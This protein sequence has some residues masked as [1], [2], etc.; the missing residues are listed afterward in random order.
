MIAGPGTDAPL[1]V[2]ISYS[3]KDR[4][5]AE[6]LRTWLMER[7]LE[8]YLDTHDI[9]PGE[10]W[11]GRIR[12]LIGRAD[13]VVFLISPDS[14]ASPICDWE[15]N[16][17]ERLGKRLLPV[18]IRDADP[19]SVPG[20]LKRLNYIF[21]RGGP[22]DRQSLDALRSTLLTDIDW[23]RNHTR[24]G[25]LAG[26]WDANKRPT[27]RELRGRALLDA[28]RWLSTRPREAP[29]PTPL[30]R[31]FIQESRKGE[32]ALIGRERA[33][34]RA[35][36]RW[37]QAAVALSCLAVFCLIVWLFQGRLIEQYRWRIEMKPAVLT[38]RQEADLAAKPGSNFTECAEGCP[39][40]VVV[41]A[42]QFLMGGD[43]SWPTYGTYGEKLTPRHQVT[44]ARP[45]AVAKTPVT[46][47]EW[48]ACV[49]AGA[50]PAIADTLMGQRDRPVIAVNWDQAKLYAA[51]LARVT[52]QRYRLLSEAEFEYAARGIT[53]PAGPYTAYSW[54]DEIGTNNANCSGCGSQWEGSTAPVA[55][56]KPNA[57]GLYDMNGNVWQWLEDTWHASYA[58]APQDGSAWTSDS[59]PNLRASRGGSFR[60]EPL[61]LR[62]EV[63]A[64]NTHTLRYEDHGLRVARI[65]LPPAP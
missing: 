15:V 6:Q 13:S 39:E 3:R 8:A 23:V 61:F 64:G 1:N 50:C 29:E 28:E 54:G 21:L 62:L 27:E 25:E 38:A 26:E 40:M 65:L 47:A 16:E 17:T 44:I 55:S 51:W 58:G 14:V 42:G 36:Q 46:F 57:F 20:R 18:V 41:P 30:H 19:E 9:L 31:A 33:K 24:L 2:F 56:F 43:P 48:Q 22:E 35:M 32:L 37:L 53:D 63:R 52:G 4:A 5:A 12:Q 11:Q 49:A 45:F 7:K 60:S 10:D 59:D 34:L